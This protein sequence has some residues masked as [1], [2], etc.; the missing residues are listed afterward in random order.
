VK[1][2]YEFN[3]KL[4]K[5]YIMSDAI[6]CNADKKLLYKFFKRMVCTAEANSIGALTLRI[7]DHLGR[8]D[9]KT[10]SFYDE[11]HLHSRL[12]I[13]IVEHGDYLFLEVMPF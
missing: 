6:Q 13:I 2:V 1:S 5:P 8:T 9:R 12:N 4:F 10:H 7:E 3:P 11:V